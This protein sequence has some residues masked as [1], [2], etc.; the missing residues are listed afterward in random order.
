MKERD[1]IMYLECYVIVGDSLQSAFFSKKFLNHACRDH[2][3][4]LEKS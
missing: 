3:T 2:Y 4:C 1:M